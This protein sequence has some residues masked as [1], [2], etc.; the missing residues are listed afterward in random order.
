MSCQSSPV[1]NRKNV[2]KSRVGRARPCNWTLLRM[3]VSAC[4]TARRAS[5]IRPYAVTNQAATKIAAK[6]A[7]STSP[8][9]MATSSVDAPGRPRVSV[10]SVSAVRAEQHQPHD[11]RRR[12]EGDEDGRCPL[13]RQSR[14]LATEA[15]QQPRQGK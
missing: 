14:Y 10:L 4:R 8:V 15:S 2:T 7:A 9:P 6:V 12:R 5:G 3:S 11:H 1:K 13:Q